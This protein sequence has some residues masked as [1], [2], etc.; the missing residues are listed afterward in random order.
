[1]KKKLLRK[2]FAI[3]IAFV[4]LGNT[5]T[6][7]LAAAA[8]NVLRS[9]EQQQG[10]VLEREITEVLD[11]YYTT[12]DESD[13][14]I[15]FNALLD[16][17][18]QLDSLNYYDSNIA[19]LSAAF[20]TINSISTSTSTTSA[21]SVTFNYTVLGKIPNGASVTI[22]WEYPANQRRPSV[23]FLATTTPGTYTKTVNQLISLSARYYTELI[24]RD[25]SDKEVYSIFTGVLDDGAFHYSS[26]II[27]AAEIRDR[28][29]AQT[30]VGIALSVILQEK[31][32][33]I[34]LG[35]YN[36]V[37]FLIDINETTPLCENQYYITG[38]RYD[39][40]TNTSYLTYARYSSRA[41]Y[42]AGDSPLESNT[43]SY[44]FGTY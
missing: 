34:T 33:K 35:L 15:L 27:T 31:K 30:L 23:T 7:S 16:K 9:S 21:S 12:T 5:A 11:V 28:N 42:L 18:S 37:N 38:M 3:G 36:A 41:S 13:Q 40:S 32:I 19:P 29:I 24:A 14:E 25:Y 17:Y 43:S 1:M 39:K 8:E 44:Y 6:P 20:V 26:H 22:G 10:R 4:V 2:L